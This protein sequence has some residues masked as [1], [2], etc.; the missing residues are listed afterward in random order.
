MKAI[1]AAITLAAFTC[2]ASG[3]T[4]DGP[5]LPYEDAGACPFEG[6]KYREWQVNAAA[7]I[8]AI[9][10]DDS[11]ILATVAKGEK[12][13]ALTGVVVTIKASRVQFDKTQQ[14]SSSAG[15]IEVMPGQTLYLLTYLGEG[16]SRAWLNGTLYRWVDISGVTRADGWCGFGDRSRCAGRELEKP[17]TQWWV[18]IRT[19][20]GKVG[21]TRET[22]KFDGK[23]ALGR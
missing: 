12:V 21:W 4:P 16:N 19:A 1:R 10:R 3:Q 17:E 22:T 11:P 9:R 23:D 14:L 5:P 6:C 20:A 2:I 7:S 15:P 8:H 13:Q 18:Q